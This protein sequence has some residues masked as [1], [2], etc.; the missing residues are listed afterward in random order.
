MNCLQRRKCPGEE[1]VSGKRKRP[2]MS[3]FKKAD[4][5]WNFIDD[6][7]RLFP[8]ASEKSCV[9]STGFPGGKEPACQ[10]K[11]DVR[12]MGSTP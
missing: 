9:P 11:F 1:T 2:E 8:I 6:F 3:H 4:L 7:Q 5:T 10:C 12:D